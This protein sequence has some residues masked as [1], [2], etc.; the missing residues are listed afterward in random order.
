MK[1]NEKN[2]LLSG[3]PRIELCYEKKL[4]NKV[5]NIDYYI[6]IPVGNKYFA[7]F[8]TYKNKN[9][10]FILQIDRQKN[11]IKSILP[12]TSCFKNNLCCGNGTIVYGTIFNYNNHKLFNI[13]DIFYYKNIDISN[14]NNLEKLKKTREMFNYIKQ[15]SYDETQLMFGIPNMTNDYAKINDIILNSPYK[16][17]SI[18]HRFLR[19]N[20]NIFYNEPVNT[21]NISATFL[22]KAVKEPDTY[23]LFALKHHKVTE[24]SHCLISTYKKSIF[25]NNLFRNIRE[26]D[27]LDYLEESEDE[28]E[29]ENTSENKFI[30]LDKSIIFRCVYNRKIKLWEPMNVVTDKISD[31]NDILEI[32]KNK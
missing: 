20:I 2:H 24:H 31:I 26:N 15:V 10:V 22:I 4:H 1:Y 5:R 7:W 28:D 8:K 23:K 18:Q 32:E 19:K 27:N 6:T 25:M 17:Y 12:V 14:L 9:Y 11:K 21:Y 30:S 13:E 16:L 29:F 3:F